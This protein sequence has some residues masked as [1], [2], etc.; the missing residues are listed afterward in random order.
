MK[1]ILFTV[2]ILFACII[3][4]VAQEES[5]KIEGRL[6]TSVNGHLLLV[7]DTE[8]GMIDIGDVTV[9][10]GIFEFTGRMPKMTVTYLM[11]SKKDVVLAIIMLE[12]ADYTITGGSDGWI[13]EGGGEAQKIWNEFNLLNKHLIRSQQRL[14]EKARTAANPA[15]L[16]KLQQEL[17]EIVTK[18]EA[19][20][21][22]LLQKYGNS[23]V[24]AYVAASGILQGM[25][26]T[27]LTERYNVLD[28]SAKATFYGKQLADELVK[29]QNVA[30]GAV[31]PDFTAPL[32]DGGVLSL[33][34]T[35]ANVK[36]VDFWASWSA[37]CR[38]EN[39][40]FLTMYKRYRPKGL[41]IISVSIDVSKQAWLSAIGQDGSNWKNVSDLKGQASEI[42]A[43]YRV[44]AIPCTF[45]LDEDNRIVAKN[46]RGKELERMI[47]EMLK[48]KK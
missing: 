38:E 31:A 30:I 14:E 35:P 42:A 18:V 2:C 45:I 26:E 29:M 32:A 25:D 27:R 20:E 44:R 47:V 24:A 15:Q 22:T 16:Q 28:E 3:T 12:N 46:I 11:T 43:A 1:G 34:E 33:Y 40:N 17:Q 41:E 37:P 8:Q 7:A 36:I 4:S 10:N 48:K 39:V 9:T 23:V 5:Y 19:E 13:V 21:L 6:D